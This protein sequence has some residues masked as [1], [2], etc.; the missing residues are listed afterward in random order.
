MTD[1][2]TELAPLRP[3]Q[4]D[5]VDLARVFAGAEIRPRARAVDGADV[6]T[7]WDLWHG[8]ELSESDFRT[9]PPEALLAP[10]PTADPVDRHTRVS[11][12]APHACVPA[13]TET[14]DRPG[15]TLITVPEET[16]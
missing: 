2:P 12:K 10:L 4:R 5:V 8:P 16:S 6:E 14:L 15:P 13:T 1:L 3:E 7:P 11:R 9:V